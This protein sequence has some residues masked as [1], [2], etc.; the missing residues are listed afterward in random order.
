MQGGSRLGRTSVEEL[1]DLKNGTLPPIYGES[2]MGIGTVEPEVKQEILTMKERQMAIFLA[3]ACLPDLFLGSTVVGVA[4]FH[5][6]RESGVSLYCLGLQA[7][8]H[9]ISSL[10]LLVRLIGEYRFP[11]EENVLNT[12]L[13]REKRLKDLKRERFF[14]ILMGVVLML[15]STTLLFKALRKFSVWQTWYMDKQS[16]Y[17]D[18]AWA[19]KFLALYGVV[20]YLT[21]ASVRLYCYFKLEARII[22]QGFVVSVISVAFLFVLWLASGYEQMKSDSYEYK[23]KAEPIA[24]LILSIATLAEAIYIVSRHMKAAEYYLQTSSHG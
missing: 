6:W 18:V 21:H 1:Q 22:F 20:M 17:R 23:W 2:K 16:L 9:M 7:I 3:T 8:A 10:L 5:A 11:D 12:G 14:S 15:S 24:A 4:M 13:L 19:T